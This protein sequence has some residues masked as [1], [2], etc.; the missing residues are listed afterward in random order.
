MESRHSESD[1]VCVQRSTVAV[2][3]AVVQMI[4]WPIGAHSAPPLGGG[5]AACN[6][7]ALTIS[8]SIIVLLTVLSL[9]TLVLITYKPPLVSQLRHKF[10]FRTRFTTI[11]SPN[12][13]TTRS[14][15]GIP[16]LDPQSPWFST[17][18]RGNLC[19]HAL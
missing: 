18:I 4:G 8:G 7:L 15:R 12:A 17:W 10:F 19:Q 11:V 3:V 9:R 13:T 16:H 14:L 2:K 5:S 6:W 1:T